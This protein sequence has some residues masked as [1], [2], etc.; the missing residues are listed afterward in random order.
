M[1]QRFRTQYDLDYKSQVFFT[2]PGEDEDLV[3][4]HMQAECD[5]NVIMARYQKTGDISHLGQ[6]AGEYGDFSDVL[7]YKTG[8]ERIM[9]ADALFMELPSSVR[10]RFGNDPAQFMEFATDASNLDEMRKMGLAPPAPE[11]PEAPLTRKDF[12]ELVDA[13]ASAKKTNPKGDQ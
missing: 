4:H 3:Q 11:K 1:T 5:V 6:I 9:D 2:D 12:Q 13:N 10:D 8:L 7:D